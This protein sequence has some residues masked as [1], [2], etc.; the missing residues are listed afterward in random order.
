MLINFMEYIKEKYL[1]I[2]LIKTCGILFIF[3]IIFFVSHF[4]V[5]YIAIIIN[6]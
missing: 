3:I 2:S 1:I 4:M 5:I 6:S